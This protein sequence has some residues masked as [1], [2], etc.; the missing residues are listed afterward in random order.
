MEQEM[1]ASAMGTGFEVLTC[2]YR[3]LVL[4]GVSRCKLIGGRDS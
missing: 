1:S 4:P 2:V 3:P